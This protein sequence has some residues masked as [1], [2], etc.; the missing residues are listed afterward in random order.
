MNPVFRSRLVGKEFNDGY[1]EGLFAGTPP[2]E[3][4]RYMLREAATREKGEEDKVLM[5][6]DVARA[7]F[8]AP[9]SRQVCVEL[10][11]EDL[12]E[13]ER[14]MDLVGLLKKNFYG[15]R[16]AAT[17]WQEEVAK[18][19]LGWGVI[20]GTY[21]PCLCYHP[22]WKLR[23]LVHGDDF[24]PVGFRSS[25][26]EMRA[27]LE[28]RF[29]IKTAVIGTGKEEESEGRILNRIVRVTED[30]WEYE[31]DQRH[32]VMIVNSLGFQVAKPVDS[33]REDET[34][35]SVVY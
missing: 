35:C 19:M 16:D 14:D 7:F 5:I 28:K 34:K 29:E 25:M 13:E 6:N 22:K 32:A 4:L 31:P 18:E 21:N 26:K 10:P 33:P 9:A 1:E 8:E 24:V 27:A 20:R 30:G 3:A 11:D 2:L 12:T 17:N 23:T 15:T